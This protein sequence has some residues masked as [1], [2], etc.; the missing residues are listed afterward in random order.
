MVLRLFAVQR[1][2]RIPIGAPLNV[3]ILIAPWP[4]KTTENLAQLAA[5]KL[6]FRPTHRPKLR[7]IIRKLN[8]KNIGQNGVIQNHTKN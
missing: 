3:K 6:L 5:A 7:A 1:V 2:A 4:K 8:S